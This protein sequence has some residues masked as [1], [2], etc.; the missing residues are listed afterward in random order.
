MC[1]YIYIY[2]IVL[3][4]NLLC[5]FMFCFTICQCLVIISLSIFVIVYCMGFRDGTCRSLF[6][7]LV[8]RGIWS[9]NVSRLFHIPNCFKVKLDRH[10]ELHALSIFQEHLIMKQHQIQSGNPQAELVEG[11]ED[12]ARCHYAEIYRSGQLEI[13]QAAMK[14]AKARERAFMED[15]CSRVRSISC[16]FYPQQTEFFLPLIFSP[17][18]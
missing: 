15:C 9:L 7:P 2:I 3:Y 17:N 14:A 13:L 12:W 1:I 5:Y 18:A 10:A 16:S 11:R 8:C 6:P 4:Y